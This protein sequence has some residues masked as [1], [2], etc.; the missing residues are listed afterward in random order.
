MAKQTWRGLWVLLTPMSHEDYSTH[1][2]MA[3]RANKGVVLKATDSHRVLRDHVRKDQ[4]SITRPTAHRSHPPAKRSP[5]VASIEHLH[6][7]P[8]VTRYGDEIVFDLVRRGPDNQGPYARTYHPRSSA[9]IRLRRPGA[10]TPSS[11]TVDARLVRCPVCMGTGGL[12]V[13]RPSTTTRSLRNWV[14]SAKNLI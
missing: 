11:C 2:A 3:A 8:E 4:L 7:H 9:T 1:C 14:R 6:R 13:S 5:I 12:S 10:A